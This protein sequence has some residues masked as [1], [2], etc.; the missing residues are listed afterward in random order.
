ME[1]VSTL[2][3][4]ATSSLLAV[5]MVESEVAKGAPMMGV[6]ETFSIDS[7]EKT[8]TS[9]SASTIGPVHPLSHYIQATQA[10]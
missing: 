3:E 4:G 7:K 10:T 6:E 9:A 5:Y 8:L 1:L 2:K